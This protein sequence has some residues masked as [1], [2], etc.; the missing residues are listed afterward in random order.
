MIDDYVAIFLHCLNLFILL[1]VFTK[2]R[3]MFVGFG[4]VTVDLSN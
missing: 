2:Y 1:I 3:R 4:S